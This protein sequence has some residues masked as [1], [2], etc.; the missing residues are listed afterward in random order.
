M[1]LLTGPH[2]WIAFF[3]LTAL[4]LALGIDNITIMM[5][6]AGPIGR[7]VSRHPTVKTSGGL[8]G[9]PRGGAVAPTGLEAAAGGL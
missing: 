4:E 2:A 8:G 6:A 9:D 1:E 3:T 5:V 7:F